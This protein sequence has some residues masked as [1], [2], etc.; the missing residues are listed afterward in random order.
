M[1]SEHLVESRGDTFGGKRLSDSSLQEVLKVTQDDSTDYLFARFTRSLM[2]SSILVIVQGAKLS[3]AY[4]RP[5]A[6]ES[7]IFG[8]MA[9]FEF[10]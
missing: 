9:G 7:P 1:L 6:C 3:T 10:P 8:E 2:S 5:L 4:L